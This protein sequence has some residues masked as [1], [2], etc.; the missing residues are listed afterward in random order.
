M[1]KRQK[2]AVG[3]IVFV[4]VSAYGG[5][6]WYK[7]S[8][9]PKWFATVAIGDTRDTVIRK[10][11]TPDQVQSKPHWLFCNSAECDSEFMY[12]HSMPPEWWVVGFNREG[13]TVWMADL[14]SP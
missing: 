3:L 1:K 2:L 10:M 5:T 8:N 6:R 14:R 12:G 7:L 11:G 9:Y 13:R 4:A